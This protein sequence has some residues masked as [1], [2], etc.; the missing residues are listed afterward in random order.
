MPERV[1]SDQ[2][3]ELSLLHL[4]LECG[5]SERCYNQTRGVTRFSIYGSAKWAPSTQPCQC[6]G[7]AIRWYSV[8]ETTWTGSTARASSR[9]APVLSPWPWAPPAP[10][11]LETSSTSTATA[12]RT[13]TPPVCPFAGRT[14]HDHA[15]GRAL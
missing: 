12:L 5:V 1:S 10:P 7:R 8:A 13:A 3:S 6:S 14:V 2:V 9:R 4:L 11:G 15:F